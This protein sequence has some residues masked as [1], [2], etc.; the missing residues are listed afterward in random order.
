MGVCSTTRR[1]RCSSDER[2]PEILHEILRPPLESLTPADSKPAT[3][4]FVHLAK[5][6]SHIWQNTGCVHVAVKF[7]TLAAALTN[8]AEDAYALV[9]L[10]RVM[11]HFTEKDSFA[12][13]GAAK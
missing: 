4:R 13:A 10:D 12:N 5:N 6:H 9:M 7:F 11:Y 2:Y 1:R 8:S 3:W